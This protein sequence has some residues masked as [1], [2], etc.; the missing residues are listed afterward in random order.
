MPVSPN[1]SA[2]AS[3]SMTIRSKKLSYLVS[4]IES[5][6]IN[7]KLLLYSYHSRIDEKFFQKYRKPALQQVHHHSNADRNDEK[8]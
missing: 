8:C 4:S 7:S 3:F 2:R 6:L 5:L 1:F